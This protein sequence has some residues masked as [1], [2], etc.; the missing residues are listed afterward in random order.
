M[1]SNYIGETEIDKPDRSDE[2]DRQLESKKQVVFYG[3][4]GT[5]KTYV[6][7]NFARWWT[8][9]Q[10]VDSPAQSR[11]E[12]VTFHPSFTY[13][14]FIEGL[15]AESNDSGAVEYSVE[16]GILKRISKNARDDYKAADNDE[17]APRYVLVID[18]I[19][20]GNIAQIFG[21]TI[22]LLE[23]DKRDE[24]FTQLAHSD[25]RFTVPPNLYVI[26]TMNT[27]D[28]S[29]S[30]VDAAL[31][32]RFRFLP[33]PPDMNELAEYHGMEGMEEVAETASE[34]EDGYDVLMSLSIIAL[35][36]TNEKIL[37]SPD[38]GKGKQIGHSYLMGVEDTQGLVD[39]W[40]YDILPLLEEYYFGQFDRI[41]QD[42]FEG[43]GSALVD[44]ERERV[45]DFDANDLLETL[46]ELVDIDAVV[47]GISSNTDGT[48]S[49]GSTSRTG[50]EYVESEEDMYEDL[51]EK[52][53]NG[54][55]SEEEHEAF[56]ELYRFAEELSDDIRIGGAKNA[57]FK[58]DVGA[59]KGRYE[60]RTSVF[61]V[62]INGK[63]KVWPAKRPIDGSN[64]SEN[65]VEWG[66]EE[67]ERYVER[68]QSLE[69][70]PEDTKADFD[71]LTR[72]NNLEKF[73][74]IVR[75]FVSH[76]RE[77]EREAQE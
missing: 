23:D 63:I 44:W 26:G 75:D 20:R 36:R 24:V 62:N 22:T 7:Q 31:R 55:I 47:D 6:A 38:L 65:P 74:E 16:D 70:V 43:G 30:L 14:D 9:Q 4:P 17:E 51:E 64:E 67:L 34:S 49:S 60:G 61:S 13:E 54:E 29:I 27:A 12:T 41:R 19:N 66:I 72:G 11:F 56:D 15:S 77:A 42:I 37:D 25:E 58:M 8:N 18:E 71:V 76:C 68:F 39:T 57:N 53:E 5:G 33:F 46:G 73:K 52:L 69:G 45:R 32:R 28:R 1:G 3:P 59:H 21:E 50:S 10:D 48:S 40:K 35:K 2:I